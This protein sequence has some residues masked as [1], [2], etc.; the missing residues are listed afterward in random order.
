MGTVAEWPGGMGT[1]LFTDVG[2]STPPWE[3]HTAASAQ[4]PPRHAAL[5]RLS[6]LPAGRAT[7]HPHLPPPPAGSPPLTPLDVPS[8]RAL[9]RALAAAAVVAAALGALLP[10]SM[11]ETRRANANA[12]SVLRMLTLD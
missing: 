8:R 3:H 4:R 1:F 6:T 5:P 9:K 2:G 10:R 7:S 11:H 12:E